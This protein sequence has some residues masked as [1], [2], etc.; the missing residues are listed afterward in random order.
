MAN[1][2]E[3]ILQ[4]TNT[5]TS[6]LDKFYDSVADE[7]L[8]WMAKEYNIELK[9]LKE[10]AAPLKTKLLSKATDAVSAVKTTKKQET[11]HK[12]VDNSRYG[13]M[14][15]KELVELCKSRT[16]PVKRKNQDMIDSLKNYDNTH[17][18]QTTN[19][20]DVEPNVESDNEEPEKK[21]NNNVKP[22][23]PVKK[24]VIPCKNELLE[25]SLDSSDE[26]DDY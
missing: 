1:A 25:E 16:L 18:Q 11:K 4:L 7:Y 13:S 20:S 24:E 12:M 3:V 10:K 2:Q 5:W 15:R 14:T 8:S 26:E 6:M 23:K 21:I 22:V 19:N 9:S 17:N